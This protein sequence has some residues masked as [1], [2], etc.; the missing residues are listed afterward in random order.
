MPQMVALLRKSLFE[1]EADRSRM[2]RLEAAKCAILRQQIN[3]VALRMCRPSMFCTTVIFAIS[4]KQY[5]F[6]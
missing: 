2:R 6:A 5:S 3:E 1:V 4:R